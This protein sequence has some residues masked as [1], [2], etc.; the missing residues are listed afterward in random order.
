[1]TDRLKQQIDDELAAIA[2]AAAL[3]SARAMGLAGAAIAEGIQQRQRT[4][5]AVRRHFG[6]LTHSEMPER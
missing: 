4:R 3:M 2:G 6:H 1:M 5:A